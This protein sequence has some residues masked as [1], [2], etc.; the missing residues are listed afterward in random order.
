MSRVLPRRSRPAFSLVELLVVIAIIS[1]LVGLLLPAVQQVREAGFRTQ[2]ANN[3]HQIGLALHLYH[4]SYKHLPPTR[5]V[6]EGPSWAWKIL[7]FMEQG[8]LARLWQDGQPYPGLVRGQPVTQQT[9][10]DISQVMRASVPTYFCPSRRDVN[11]AFYSQDFAQPKAC[12][13]LSGLPGAVGDYAASIGTTGV[14]YPL[15]TPTG[16][17]IPPDGAFT[18]INGIRFAQ[19]T[20]GLSNTFMVGEKHVPLKHFGQ[21]PWDCSIYDG[22]NPICNTRAAGP[23]FP[24]A[25]DLNDLG[26][27]FGSYHPY[28]C[29]FVYCDGS[30]QILRASTNPITLG[31]LAQR[32]DGQA[33]PE[34]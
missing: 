33:I 30:V 15:P 17:S 21:Y 7:P 24:L 4:D 34:Y 16:A 6:A 13:L 8:D 31:L 12:L 29:Q 2:C 32:N 20:D 3:L 10:D 22:H 26:W 19:I 23:S 5:D 28:L 11:D 27:K 18:A 25:S 1:I 9:V 14:D